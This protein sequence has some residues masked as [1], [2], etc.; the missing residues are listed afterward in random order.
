LETTGS[1]AGASPEA[2]RAIGAQQDS[3]V[4][5]CWADQDSSYGGVVGY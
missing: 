3:I 2:L 4:E 5:F 1:V